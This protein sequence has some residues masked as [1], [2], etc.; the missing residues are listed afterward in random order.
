MLDDIK[1]EDDD[2]YIKAVLSLKQK[3]DDKFDDIEDW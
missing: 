2:A 1:D 3:L